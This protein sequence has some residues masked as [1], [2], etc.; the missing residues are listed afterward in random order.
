MC[1]LKVVMPR[2][3]AFSPFNSFSFSALCRKKKE[4]T[5]EVVSILNPD[6]TSFSCPSLKFHNSVLKQL[7]AYC[8]NTE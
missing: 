4:H 3:M 2:Q 1:Y 8:D 5:A 6:V 7:E